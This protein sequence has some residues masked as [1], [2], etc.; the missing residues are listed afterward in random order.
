[1]WCVRVCCGVDRCDGAGGGAGRGRERS[2]FYFTGFIYI[3]FTLEKPRSGTTRHNL[4][5]AT[6]ELCIT[7]EVLYSRVV[8]REIRKIEVFDIYF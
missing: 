3:R 6:C 4:V 7:F 1:V 8:Q 2:R 5:N